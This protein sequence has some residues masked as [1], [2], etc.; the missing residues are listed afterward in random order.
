VDCA[1]ISVITDGAPWK[2]TGEDATPEVMPRAL[3]TLQGKVILCPTCWRSD[4]PPRRAACHGVDT[5]ET[6]IV[7]VATIV[8]RHVRALLLL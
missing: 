6:R 3:V 2:L 4:S 5:I 1:D 8:T 7:I